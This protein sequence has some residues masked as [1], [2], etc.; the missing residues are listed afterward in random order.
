VRSKGEEEMTVVLHLW[1][2]GNLILSEAMPTKKP[3]QAQNIATIWSV[4]MSSG[5]ASNYPCQK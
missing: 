3:Q 4:V 2:E 5:E 1:S